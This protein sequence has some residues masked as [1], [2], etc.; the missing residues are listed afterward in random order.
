MNENKDE[1][2]NC[3]SIPKKIHKTIEILLWILVIITIFTLIATML[4]NYDY[5]NMQ[6]KIGYKMFQIMLSIT[7]IV[8][9]VSLYDFNTKKGMSFESVGCIVIAL[10]SLLFMFFNVN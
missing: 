7:M 10:I 2:C 3:T 9:S 8:G 1:Q 5:I 4:L 6:Y